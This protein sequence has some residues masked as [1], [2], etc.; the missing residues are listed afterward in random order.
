DRGR[1]RR[2][3]S[4]RGTA[5]LGAGTIRSSGAGRLRRPHAADRLRPRDVATDHR[6]LVGG[7]GDEECAARPGVSAAGC[8]PGHRHH[9]RHLPRRPARQL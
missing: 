8:V 6:P 3:R 5:G 2:S 9:L 7:R 1:V 4:P